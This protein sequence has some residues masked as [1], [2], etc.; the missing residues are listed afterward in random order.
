MR[1]QRSVEWISDGIPRDVI[2]QDLLYSLGAFLTVCQISRND[3]ERRIKALLADP[4]TAVL[5]RETGPARWAQR[6]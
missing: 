6:P 4:T 2:D 5:K 3:A 1:H